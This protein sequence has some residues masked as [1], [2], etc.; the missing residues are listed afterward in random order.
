MNKCFLGLPIKNI[1]FQK[2]GYFF[3][4]F[5][6][7]QFFIYNSLHKSNKSF[8]NFQIENPSSSKSLSQVYWLPKNFS[9]QTGGFYH[10][11]NFYFNNPI[12]CGQIFWVG[13]EN[14]IM[15]Y[16]NLFLKGSSKKW[17]KKTI[18]IFYKL[19]SQGKKISFP[20]P[21]PNKNKK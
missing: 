1:K 3:S 19:T 17:L 2:L 8:N 18:P 14:Y 13:E 15:E 11:D 16:G 21:R 9:T 5:S 10:I 12:T 6:N 20:C 7:D 4:L